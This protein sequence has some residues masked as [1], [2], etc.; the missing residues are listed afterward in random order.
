M[1]GKKEEN[2]YD[3]AIR[4]N[5]TIILTPFNTMPLYLYWGK[6]EKMRS[7]LKQLS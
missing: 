4:T 5:H 2:L 1:W 6:K 3:L 7:H